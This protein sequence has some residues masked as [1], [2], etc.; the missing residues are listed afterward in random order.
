MVTIGTGIFIGGIQ[1]KANVIWLFQN[2][3][4]CQGIG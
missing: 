3:Q 4:I 1:M 2:G